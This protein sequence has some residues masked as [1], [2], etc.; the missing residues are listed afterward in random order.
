MGW[1][2]LVARMG[3][4]Y[5]YRVC[6]GNW[7][8]TDQLEDLDLDGRKTKLRLKKWGRRLWTVFSC[9]SAGTGGRL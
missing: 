7:K 2:G 4:S 1:N 8:E 6:G 9:M 5:T 3:R